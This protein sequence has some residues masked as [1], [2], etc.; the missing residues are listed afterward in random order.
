MHK[1]QK[2]SQGFSAVINTIVQPSQSTPVPFRYNTH[3][4]MAVL[5]SLSSPE[6]NSRPQYS[7]EN[8]ACSPIFQKAEVQLEPGESRATAVCSRNNFYKL[9][10]I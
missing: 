8:V 9:F 3:T 6:I 10:N 2:E 7:C 5:T 1:L 4:N